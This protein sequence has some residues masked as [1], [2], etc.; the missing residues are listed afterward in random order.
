MLGDVLRSEIV[1]VAQLMQSD[2]S[3]LQTHVGVPLML[4]EVSGSTPCG[5]P[6][7]LGDCLS[8]RQRDVFT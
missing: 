1:T 2:V 3:G 5:A 8:I 7:M 4:S 6:P